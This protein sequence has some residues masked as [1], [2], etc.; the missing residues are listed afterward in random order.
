MSVTTSAAQSSADPE[1]AGSSFTALTRRI[2]ELGLMRRRYGYYWTKLV[3]AVLA[4]AAWVVG[5]RLDRRLLVAARSRAAVLAVLMTQIAF[6]GHDAAHRQMFKSGR[7]NDWVSLVVANLL[8]RHQLRL[9]AEQ[10]H[11]APRQP[12]QGRRRPRHRPRRDRLHPGAGEP[13][14]EP[15]AA[16]ARRPPGLVLLPAA[17]ARGRCPCTGTASS[18][19]SAGARCERRWVEMTFL[20]SGSAACRPGLRG[21]AA[22]AK[23]SPSSPSSWPCSASTWA[24]RSPPTTSACRWSRRG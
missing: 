14:P 24:S 17:A 18:G 15:G 21:A 10:A 20:P 8:R 5:L 11:P 23:P 3:G 4:L 2:H 22:R 12:Q 6:L 7:W 16:L 19:S 1:R 9:V 13:A